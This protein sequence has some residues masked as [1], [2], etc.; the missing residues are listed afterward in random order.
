M[1]CGQQQVRARWTVAGHRGFSRAVRVGVGS[2]AGASLGLDDSCLIARFHQ[3]PIESP[4]HLQDFGPS[5]H[6]VFVLY[7]TTEFESVQKRRICMKTCHRSI[8]RLSAVYRQAIRLVH[9]R[10]PPDGWSRGDGAR[11]RMARARRRWRTALGEAR[12][13]PSFRTSS[14]SMPATPSTT[15]IRRTSATR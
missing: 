4:R 8:P 12:L 9:A 2:A 5:R 11:G 7:L 13:W 10:R 6:L 3:F 14:G 15:P 1:E